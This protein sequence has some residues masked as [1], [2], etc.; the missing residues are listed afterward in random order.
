MFKTTLIK[1]VL[2]SAALAMIAGCTQPRPPIEPNAVQ[3]GDYKQIYVDSYSLKQKT[4]IDEPPRVRRDQ[5]GLLH[6][7]VPIRSVIDPAFTLQYRVTFFDRDRQIV[8]VQD[9]TDKPLTPNTPD[10]IQANSA[11]PADDFRMDLRLPS[12]S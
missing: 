3:Y 2:G 1:L 11:V 9:W 7:S 12:G 4:N 10:I 5:Y 8:H 6:V